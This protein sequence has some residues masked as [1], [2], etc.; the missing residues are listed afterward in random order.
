MYRWVSTSR[1]PSTP[2]GAEGEA[3]TEKK[4]ALTFS[5]PV[6]VLPPSEESE[7]APTAMDVDKPAPEKPAGQVQAKCDVQ[8]C[9]ERRKYRLV[10]DF[11]KGAC[12]MAHL[13]ALE[14]QLA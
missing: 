2:G 10:R 6:S 9:S 5:V 4:M 1:V 12:G 14:T 13:K 3:S 8:G 7:S 11:A